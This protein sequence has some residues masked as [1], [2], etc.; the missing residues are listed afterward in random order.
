MYGRFGRRGGSLPHP[1][2]FDNW[3]PF[4]GGDYGTNMPG[5]QWP[6]DGGGRFGGLPPGLGGGMSSPGGM[7]GGGMPPMGGSPGGTPPMG[8]GV[9]SGMSG[10]GDVDAY[11][12]NLGA[13]S[14]NPP[15]FQTNMPGVGG[16]VS[17]GAQSPGGVANP[18]GP[19]WSAPGIGEPGGMRPGGPAGPMRPGQP[20]MGGG[21]YAG[22]GGGRTN[23]MPRFGGNQR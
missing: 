17:M 18:M 10:G 1:D 14:A 11:W 3:T 19:E 15:Q 9:P 23:W 6:G 13:F 4:G 22:G 2:E 7:G 8:G 5:L 21:G 20:P 16:G 12:R